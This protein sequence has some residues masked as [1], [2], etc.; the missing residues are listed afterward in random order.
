MPDPSGPVPD[1][2]PAGDSTGDDRQC[3]LYPI[4][5]SH[6]HRTFEIARDI[7]DGADATLLVLDL[8][9]D[10]EEIADESRRVG[11]ELLSNRLD[12]SHDLSIKTRFER[13]DDPASTV[14]TVARN[15]DTGLLVFD[16]HA[17]ESLVAPIAGDVTDRISDRVAV[18]AI[19]VE[20][21]RS[22]PIASVLVPIAAGPHSGLSVSVGGAIARSV[23]A[24]VELFHVT[25]PDESDH[26]VDELFDDATRRVPD[27]VDVDTW[28]LERESVAETIVEQSNHYDVTVVGEPTRG[29]LRRFVF[30]S[31]TDEVSEDSHNTVLVSRRSN[32]EPFRST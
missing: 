20:R 14:I 12:D 7:A 21:A 2:T 10:D 27:G 5:E 16:E 3:V 4:F 18:D 26:R 23:D 24:V 1:R 30:G 17:P 6:D 31:V 22:G 19:T 29:R 13:T 15:H 8:S 28:T 11:S 32:G 25:E 9:S